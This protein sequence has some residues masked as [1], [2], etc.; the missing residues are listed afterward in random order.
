MPRQPT[1]KKPLTPREK[2]ARYRAAMRAKGYRQVTRW[3]IDTRDPAMRAEIARQMAAIAASP[4]DSAALDFWERVGVF[5][6]LFDR[7]DEAG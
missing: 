7:D 1:R 2:A 5:E 4:D 3:V 6:E